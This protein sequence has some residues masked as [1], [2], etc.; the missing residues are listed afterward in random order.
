MATTPPFTYTS[1]TYASV[2]AALQNLV[3][4]RFPD[5]WKDF[6][7]GGVATAML[8]VVA[9]AHEQRAFYYDR[10]ALN[11][12][13]A[14]AD[15]RDAVVAIARQ[16]GYQPRP[17]TSASVPVVLA[18]TPTQG[19]P[20]T[21]PA[22]TRL[23][24]GNLVFEA[25]SDIEI[26][27]A[28]PFWPDGSTDDVAVFTEG[29][30]VLDQFVSTG[31]VFQSFKLSRSS[32]ITSTLVVRVNGVEWDA[33]DSLLFVEG[34]SLEQ[35]QFT[36]TGLDSQ[37]YVL[38][39]L[40]ATID[41]T[42]ERRLTVLVNE[43]E[44]AQVDIL[45]GRPRQYTA[46]QDAGGV[47]TLRFGLDVF[48]AAPKS[49]QLVDVRYFIEGSQNRYEFELDADDNV[50][51]RFGDGETGNIPPAG[52]AIDVTYRVGNGAVGNVKRGAIN[53]S[54]VGVLPSG[55]RVPVAVT[56]VEPGSGGEPRES[57]ESIKTNAPLFAKSN[58]RAVREQ[59][60][61]T[62]AATYR[63]VV[64]GA[65]SYAKARLKQAV[66]ELNTVV[67]ALWSRDDQGRVAAPSSSLEAGIR[68][69]M[70]SRST[71]TTDVEVE[72]GEVVFLDTDL[73][74][75]LKAGYSADEVF[76]RV[77]AAV[78]KFFGS[79]AVRPGFSFSVSRFYDVVQSVEGV[80]RA[81]IVLISGSQLV[82]FDLEDG[83]GATTVFSGT[84]PVPDGHPILPGSVAITVGTDVIV[85]DGEG[86]LVGTGLVS[87]ATNTV[88]YVS[89]IFSF[90][91]ATAPGSGVLIYGEARH[92]A[93]HPKIEDLGYSVG[94]SGIDGQTEFYPIIKRKPVGLQQSILKRCIN[95]SRVGQG[96]QY[97]GQLPGGITPSTVTFEEEAPGAQTITDNGV[98]GLFDGVTQVGTI[99]YDS[100]RYLFDFLVAPAAT[101]V[102]V[103]ASWQSD[104][105]EATFD[106]LGLPMLQGR[107][108]FIGGYGSGELIVYD[109]GKGNAAE[110]VVALEVHEVDYQTGKVRFTWN[111]TP[112]VSTPAVTPV[113]AYLT[114]APDGVT[115]QFTYELWDAPAAGGSRVTGLAQYPSANSLNGRTRFNATD[116][117]LDAVAIQDFF[118][119]WQGDLAGESLDES[120]VNVLDYAAGSGTVTFKEAPPAGVTRDI[121]LRW[122]GGQTLF[123]H[124]A[125]RA[126]VIQAAEGYE[127]FFFADNEGRL[128]GTV[129][130][131]YP[132]SRFDHSVGRY[133]AT[134][135]ILPVSGGRIELS[136][137]AEMS[138]QGRDL[139]VSDKRV[140]SQGALT[141]NERES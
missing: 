103:T 116:L 82:E 102:R 29:L 72:D 97:K 133:L 132:F 53:T 2:L 125:F 118:D 120:G 47:T 117:S 99:D 110:D 28:A 56:N 62:L 109:D 19:A 15:Q 4:V 93:S 140:V 95:F 41:A 36:G 107:L 70:L 65:P 126:G 31:D 44:W 115:K 124:S 5:E 11:S 121:P 113:Y 7:E 39:E 129:G 128:W 92:V 134:F 79:T 45:D 59:D 67:I 8:Q 105:V 40:F 63:D 61:T 86:N 38:D 18:P 32:F 130:L 111:I 1:R 37:T 46:S 69:F 34:T 131:S 83:D 100:G 12:F 114:P 49:G 66:P 33:I 96:T 42:S 64:Y 81:E 24:V 87:T 55:K 3:R 98:G 90:T 22:G 91:L 85:D 112:P 30:T 76:A 136:Y 35:Q 52:A 57:L 119:N 122:D 78:A 6:A 104:T 50:T 17:V 14:S 13:M 88:D 137:D 9:W 138:T 10:L 23:T 75:K 73:L 54:V 25:L 51:I 94:V 60:W 101:G 74:I 16:L 89:G 77:R 141:L 108:F 106:Q 123:M 58:N 80:D 27:G 71:I 139:E 135:A 48:G 84:V 127:Q 26:P 68:T 20:I 43:V 21:I